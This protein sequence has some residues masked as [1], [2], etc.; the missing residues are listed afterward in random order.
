MQMNQTN[1]QIL[2]NLWKLMK[3][4]FSFLFETKYIQKHFLTYGSCCWQWKGCIE[5]RVVFRKDF[6]ITDVN[7]G[8]SKPLHIEQPFVSIPD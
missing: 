5:W 6:P 7:F 8:G 4:F 3:T 1:K 2:E